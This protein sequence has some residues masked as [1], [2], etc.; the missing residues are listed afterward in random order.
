M[1]LRIFTKWWIFFTSSPTI[2]FMKE[3]KSLSLRS[4]VIAVFVTL[5]AA[6]MLILLVLNYYTDLAKQKEAYITYTE[7]M[8]ALSAVNLTFEL[9]Q[10]LDLT[11][12]PYMD[13]ALFNLLAGKGVE[14][15]ETELLENSLLPILNSNSYITQVHLFSEARQESFVA[16]SHNLYRRKV[17]ASDTNAKSHDVSVS[18]QKQHSYGIPF[19]KNPDG[20]VITVSRNLYDLPGRDYTGCI[21]VDVALDFFA[22]ANAT[23]YSGDDDIVAC[24]TGDGEI[25]YAYPD[26]ALAEAVLTNI[27]LEGEYGNASVRNDGV[28]YT[29]LYRKVNPGAGLDPVYIV[30][31]I[32][33]SVISRNAKESGLRTF[34]VGVITTIVALFLI[35]VVISRFLEPFGYIESQLAKVSEGNLNVSLELKDSKEFSRLAS[36][37]NAMIDTINNVIIRNYQLELENKNNQLKALQAQL[38]PHFINNTLQT[39]G[40]EALKKGNMELYSAIL[41]FGEMM[42]Y[43]MNF[44]EMKVRFGDEVAYTENYL[45]FQKMRFGDRLDYAVDVS[46]DVLEIEVPKLLLQPLVENSLKHGYNDA[47]VGV[48]R[49]Y[50]HASVE[51]GRFSM[52]CGNSGAGLSTQELSML[53]QNI[54]KARSGGGESTNIGLRNLA[55]RLQLLYGNRALLQVDSKDGRGFSVTLEIPLEDKGV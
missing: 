17:G 37:F 11:L 50:I 14:N 20:L 49:I 54:E 36:Q 32:E 30:K 9:R 12:V 42:R 29:M 16:R 18:C 4:K 13:D 34:L 21:D 31:V 1:E 22:N 33:N 15:V 8:L 52:I 40:A 43:T 3:I 26:G 48:I 10:I 44:R 38:D 47:F 39:I 23:L 35:G 7:D 5:V 2:S 53:R 19:N 24:L 28:G 25:I 55:R 41:H 51:N 45:N 27:S 46:P 6:S